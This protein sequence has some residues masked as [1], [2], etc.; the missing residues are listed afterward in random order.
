MRIL[1][2]SSSGFLRSF[3]A[4]CRRA[5]PSVSMRDSVHAILEEVRRHG[6]RA[7]LDTVERFDGI[8]LEAGR[9][10]PSPRPK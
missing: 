7:V 4:F 2:T 3:R 10:S 1:D 5:E 6:D 9:H 8:R